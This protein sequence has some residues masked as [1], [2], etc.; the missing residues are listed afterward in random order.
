MV[1]V[2][3]TASKGIHLLGDIISPWRNV[4]PGFMVVFLSNKIDLWEGKRGE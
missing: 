3:S 2:E 4:S 1:E